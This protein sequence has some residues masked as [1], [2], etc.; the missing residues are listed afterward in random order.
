MKTNIRD[1]A[2]RIID[3]RELGLELGI[4][5]NPIGNHSLIHLDDGNWLAC[6][7]RFQYYIEG[8]RYSYQSSPN[9]FYT[10][11]NHHVFVLLDRDFNLVRRIEN[12]VSEYFQTGEWASAFLYDVKDPYLEDA[13][14]TRWGNDIY[15]TSAIY[16]YADGVKRWATEIQKLELHEDHIDA[17]HFWN[18]LEH[19]IES[20]QKNWMSIP[21]RPFHFITA[22]STEAAK[23]IDITGD[24]FIESGEYNPRELYGGS[25]NL[26]KCADGYWTITHR[27][28]HG[29]RLRRTYENYIVKYDRDLRP[30]YFSRPFKFC[31]QGIEF[32]TSIVEL[33]E[34]E[35]AVCVTEMDDLPEIHI[36]NKDVLLELVSKE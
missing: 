9:M 15:L 19:G 6:F 4:L 11:S 14:F 23:Y 16:Y 1:Y 2:K 27:Y 10:D 17:H 28:F 7:R 26:L 12:P 35:V 8:D 24:R 32:V 29:Q 31:A 30:V 33:P 5:F 34:N 36:Y 20:I 18:T 13:R 22:T 3:F 25:A 21:D